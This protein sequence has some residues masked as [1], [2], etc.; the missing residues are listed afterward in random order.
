MIT[1][2]KEN[3]KNIEYFAGSKET[4]EYNRSLLISLINDLH[5]INCLLKDKNICLSIIYEDQ[6]TTY[7]PERVDP[8]P[9]FYGCFSIVNTYNNERIGDVMTLYELDNTLYLLYD[10]IEILKLN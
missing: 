9:D 3:I 2:S 7:S 5:N 10:F 8:C 1:I 4:N 6:H